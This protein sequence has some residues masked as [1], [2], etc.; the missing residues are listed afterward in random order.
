M[1]KEERERAIKYVN[2]QLDKAVDDA[3]FMED[4]MYDALQTLVRIAEQ[5]SCEDAV[6]RKE[7]QIVL[8]DEEL[9]Q[10]Q[11]KSGRELCQIVG[12]LQSI[13]APP[14]KAE[15][16]IKDIEEY[17]KPRFLKIVSVEWLN[18]MCHRS[19]PKVLDKI[20]AE[21]EPYVYE[22]K[23]EDCIGGDM[24]GWICASEVL[25]IIDKYKESEGK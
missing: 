14:K 2:A 18:E 22:N 10:V 25:R 4:E 5:E 8:L 6:S 9:D 24:T 20:R 16:T 1:K 21:I 7:L 3:N 12:S 23:Y 19:A 11:G 15:L 17:C 13:Q